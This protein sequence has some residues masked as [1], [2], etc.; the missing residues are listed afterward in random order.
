MKYATS[1]RITT[2]QSERTSRQDT[3]AGQNAISIAPPAYGIDFVDREPAGAG[4]LSVNRPSLIQAKSMTAPPGEGSGTPG[5]Y[6]KNKTGLPDNLKAGVETL[7]GLSMDDVS[8]HY[9]SAK[10]AQLQA[11]AYTQGTDIHMGPGQEGHLP[12]ETWHVVQQK[13]GRVKPTMQ[14]KGTAI[15]DDASLEN[16]A[17]VMGR[18]AN[19]VQHWTAHNERPD[20]ICSQVQMENGNEEPA[21]RKSDPVQRVLAVKDLDG[22]EY[23]DITEPGFISGAH[24]ALLVNKSAIG[25][26]II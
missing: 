2:R 19:A 15:N 8:V 25:S 5:G 4:S 20:P 26:V 23:T 21:Q 22:T 13:Q 12:H 24:M 10:P 11:L 6:K 18:R 3:S 16:E 1:E 9:N 7:S 17:D 14:M